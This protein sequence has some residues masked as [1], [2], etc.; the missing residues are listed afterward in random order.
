MRYVLIHEVDVDYNEEIL[1]AISVVFQKMFTKTM[2][3][4]QTKE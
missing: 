2:V 3:A 1:K 4:R